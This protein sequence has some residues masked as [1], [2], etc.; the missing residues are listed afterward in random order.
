MEYTNYENTSYKI[1]FIKTDKFKTIT[2]R[3][4]F[5]S[6]IIKE[7]IVYRNMLSLI[8]FESS[9][10]YKTRRLIDIECENLYNIG[11]G[12]GTMISGNS[13]ILSFNATFLNEK[14]T[15][16]GMLNKSIDFIHDIILW[17]L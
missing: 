10:K 1:H 12:S 2:A 4:V 13:N 11:V 6:P 16:K 8:L 17:N 3:V 5:H 9:K 14:Y 7:K 15:E